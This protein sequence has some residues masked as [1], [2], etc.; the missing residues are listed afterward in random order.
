MRVIENLNQEISLMLFPYECTCS[1][2]S[3]LYYIPTSITGIGYIFGNQVAIFAYSAVKENLGQIA[4]CN[5]YLSFWSINDQIH[6]DLTFCTMSLGCKKFEWKDRTEVRIFL[7][8]AFFQGMLITSYFFLLMGAVL[9]QIMIDI[10]E[11]VGLY[12][13]WEE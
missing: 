9:Y 2:T 5:S 12:Y 4:N 8:G 13:F 1:V 6:P 11:L 7:F 3:L 10:L